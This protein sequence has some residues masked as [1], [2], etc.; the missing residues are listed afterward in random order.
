MNQNYFESKNLDPQEANMIR[1]SG[2]LGH[3]GI[4]AP[5]STTYV[6][7]DQDILNIYA[8]FEMLA[9]ELLKAHDANI[10]NEHYECTDPIANLWIEQ[11]RKNNN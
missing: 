6:N 5:F 1:N 7:A 8:T 9:K 10:N 4:L 11:A 2:I 3:Y